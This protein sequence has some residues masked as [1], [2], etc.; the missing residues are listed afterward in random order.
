M[1]FA[2]RPTPTPRSRGALWRVS[3][4]LCLLLFLI[5]PEPARAG[6]TD[7][8]VVVLEDGVERPRDVAGEHRNRY[9]AELLH[10]Y[11]HALNGYAARLSEEAAAAIARD[12]RVQL[13][14]PDQAISTLGQVVPTGIERIGAPANPGTGIDGRDDVRVDADIAIIDTGVDPDHPDLDVVTSAN[15]IGSGLF[16]GGCVSGGRDDNGHGTHVAGTAAA[17]DNDLGVV[18]VAPGARLHAVKVLAAS[19]DGLMSD[20]VA[21]IDWV[22]SHADTIEVAN[23][24][25]GCRCTMASLDV[26]IAGSVEAGIVH[27]V[28]AG[29]QDED[30]RSYSPAGHPDAITV[31]ALA[32]SDGAPGGQ[33]PDTCTTDQDD[34]LGDYSNW[35]PAVD[36]A[37]PGTCIY[38]T[39]TLG[40]YATMTGTSMASPHV[41]G[42]AALMVSG[43]NDARTRGDVEFVRAAII[44]SGSSEWTD[45]SGDGIFEPLLDVGDAEVF[46]VNSPERTLGSSAPPPSEDPPANQAPVAA[47]T[48]SCSGLQCSFDAT[49]SYDSDGTIASYD[50][51]LG[52]GTAASGPTIQK[53]FDSEGIYTVTL[54]VVDDYGASDSEIH[55]IEVVSPG[56]ED[57]AFT[58]MG[59]ATRT[60]SQTTHLYWQGTDLAG[61]VVIFRNGEAI[62]TTSDDGTYTDFIPAP[63]GRYVYKACEANTTRCSNEV[64]FF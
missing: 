64:Y 61:D 31:S 33:G 49:G 3:N 10:I 27:V 23:M 15:C 29:N 4:A 32:D 37:A 55:E 44:S 60:G 62:V 57:P 13:V 35:G 56:S 5:A 30:A 34:T 54:T 18:G 14:E 36:V 40:R 9:G 16:G 2:R 42:A 22:T 7:R 20:V 50:W 59:T 19:G 46:D 6:G 26:A 58:L 21:G 48:H 51:D 17:I 38:S 53:T 1:T 8:F 47:F 43:A 63:S 45:D 11:S 39:T 12:P 52:D 41:A 24:S 28:A 25:L